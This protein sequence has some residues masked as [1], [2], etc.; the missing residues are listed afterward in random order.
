MLFRDG[1]CLWCLN[2]VNVPRWL[3][4]TNNSDLDIQKFFEIK[5][6]EVRREFIRKFGVERL[7]KF[8]K[9]EDKKGDY[10][11]IDMSKTMLS[12][13]YSPYLLMKNPTIG[14]Y[15][16]EGVARE[17]KTVEQAFNWRNQTD[18]IPEILT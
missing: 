1:Y 11:L 9:L 14:T 4:E 3:V 6:A 5:N 17:C 13:R 18:E 16:I 10:E 2:G 7:R 15:H 8:G 12:E